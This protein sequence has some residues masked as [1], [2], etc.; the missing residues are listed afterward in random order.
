METAKPGLRHTVLGLLLLVV[1]GC[2][3]TRNTDTKRSATEQILISHAV[4]QTVSQLDFR[5]LAG[6]T[7]FLEDKYLKE[8][9]DSGYLISSLR[10]HLLACGCLLQEE[11]SQ[12]TF[13]VEARVGGLGTDRH[14]LLVGIPQTTIPPL[15][16]GQPTNIPEIPLAKKTQQKA[17]AKLAVF[18]FN[19]KTGEP[20]WQSGVVQAV[21]S[22]NDL[23]LFGTGPFQHGNICKGTTFAGQPLPL[24]TFLNSGSNPIQAP[25]VPVT[26]AAHWSDHHPYH[27]STVPPTVKIINAHATQASPPPGSASSRKRVSA[28]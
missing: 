20:L 1:L 9:V 12:A 2:G 27:K 11:R 4:D 8:A 28:P 6:Q 16:P 14:D 5:F 10:Q 24:P 21:S 17:I 19:R 26:Q 3:T 13:V 23:W 15:V 22:V 7:V 18:A 25:V